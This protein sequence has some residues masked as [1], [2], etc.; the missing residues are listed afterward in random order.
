MHI[1]I[2][3]YE[4]CILY[5]LLICYSLFMN[6]FHCHENLYLSINLDLIKFKSF[7]KF[8]SSYD[9]ILLHS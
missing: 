4:Y 6:S 8:R 5:I 1:Y 2:Y 9:P 7:Y 3:K